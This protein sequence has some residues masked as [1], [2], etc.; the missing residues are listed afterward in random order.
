M[1][2][3]A[4]T[5]ISKPSNGKIVINAALKPK[6]EMRPTPHAAQP[7]ARI[8]RKMPTL[9]ITPVFFESVLFANF[10]LQSTSVNS[11]PNKILV[12]T[13]VMNVCNNTV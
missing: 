10:V 5:E 11:T 8:P 13:V 1:I 2:R 7:G 6:R 4:M 9:A 3:I 12:I